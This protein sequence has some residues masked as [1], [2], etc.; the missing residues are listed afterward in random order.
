MI[1]LLT[2]RPLSSNNRVERFVS[3]KN[4][5]FAATARRWRGAVSNGHPDAADNHSLAAPRPLGS[6]PAIWPSEIGFSAG[7]AQAL[8][9]AG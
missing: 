5:H 8:Q 1:D 7:S 3:L 2:K 6:G 9:A 4:V